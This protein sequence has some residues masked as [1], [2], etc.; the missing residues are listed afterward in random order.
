MH[1]ASTAFPCQLREQWM[2]H[3]WKQ[4]PKLS[5]EHHLGASA[6]WGTVQPNG[7]YK[8]RSRC[9]RK[10]EGRQPALQHIFTDPL[11]DHLLLWISR[12][13]GWIKTLEKPRL[14]GSLIYFVYI[15][16]V[17][18]HC[19]PPCCKI[20]NRMSKTEKNVENIYSPMVLQSCVEVINCKNKKKEIRFSDVTANSGQKLALHRGKTWLLTATSI[21][22]WSL[23]LVIFSLASHREQLK[24]AAGNGTD[25][26]QPKVKQHKNPQQGTER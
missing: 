16:G 4:S 13:S 3:M 23:R 25:D 7:Q 20:T 11:S 21:P 15:M 5:R 14:D 8:W 26:S 12:S 19:F 2:N 1:P 17:W 18:R 24:G 9:N 10:P 6:S 22:L